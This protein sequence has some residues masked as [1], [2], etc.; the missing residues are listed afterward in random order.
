[1]FRYVLLCASLAAGC[2]LAG[3]TLFHY[4]QLESYQFPGYFR[5]LRRNLPKSFLPGLLT[6]VVTSAVMFIALIFIPGKKS[7]LVY[8]IP[9][10]LIIAGGYG[11]GRFFYEKKAKKAL[12]YTPRMKRLYVVA[13]IVFTVMSSN[14]MKPFPKERLSAVSRPKPM[15]TTAWMP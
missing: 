2:I 8:I 13:A 9:S 5:T 7:I 10:V 11:I 3:K 15:P 12:V 1:M 4:F 6:A 14:I